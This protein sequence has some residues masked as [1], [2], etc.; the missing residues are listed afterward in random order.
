MKSLAKFILPLAIISNSHSQS[1]Q[2]YLVE[3]AKNQVERGTIEW[4]IESTLQKPERKN[5]VERNLQD[6]SSTKIIGIDSPENIV[7]SLPVLIQTTGPKT[8]TE[9]RREKLSLT[10]GNLGEIVSFNFGTYDSKLI[11]FYNLSK[12]R[13]QDLR[14]EIMYYDT[15]IPKDAKYRTH[16]ENAMRLNRTESIV[17][18][19][20]P[21]TLKIKDQKQ[22][23]E[24]L[25][26]KID[27]LKP[28]EQ[29]EQKKQLEKSKEIIFSLM[30]RWN[31]ISSE[32]TYDF[33][34]KELKE[35]EQK[36][37]SE[38]AKEINP[39]YE[40]TKIELFPSR[41]WGEMEVARSMSF[42]LEKTTKQKV[43]FSF[44]IKPA[45][46]NDNSPNG[47]EKATLEGIL[48]NGSY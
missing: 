7:D 40:A 18:F 10:T 45:F 47:T 38:L 32:E 11:F 30:N 26:G 25:S 5:L 44:Y 13:I 36:I 3:Q 28:L 39:Q 29:T 42:L 46:Q 22:E 41:V 21:L 34:E 20:H 27:S 4:A 23:A 15:N 2:E 12:K 31:L 35:R 48:L 37:M 9:V 16:P 43:P 19:F 6:L 8:H 17:Y 14:S 24:Y 33:I 1:T